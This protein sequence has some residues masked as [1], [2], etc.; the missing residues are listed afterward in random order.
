MNTPRTNSES[1]DT[2]LKIYPVV[3]EYNHKADMFCLREQLHAAIEL[4]L[5]SKL[6]WDLIEREM[7]CS[8]NH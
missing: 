3:R 8:T 4:E 7:L 5:G 1:L 2:I 6:D